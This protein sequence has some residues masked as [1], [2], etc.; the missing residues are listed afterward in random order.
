MIIVI[1]VG[2]NIHLVFEKW[3]KKNKNLL[4]SS[5]ELKHIHPISNMGIIKIFDLI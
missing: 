2:N 5:F 3:F 1:S 4:Q